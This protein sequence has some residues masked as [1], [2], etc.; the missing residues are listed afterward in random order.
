MLPAARHRVLAAH[1]CVVR[2]FHQIIRVSG[3]DQG[4]WQV[5]DSGP[6]FFVD[7]MDPFL[8]PVPR[9][10]HRQPDFCQELGVAPLVGEDSGCSSLPWKAIW[11]GVSGRC[12]QAVPKSERVAAPMPL[13]DLG[14]IWHDL[15]PEKVDALQ[16]FFRVH[17]QEV[18]SK[19]HVV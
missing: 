14:E 12:R 13:D 7:E 2:N 17:A 1:R 3:V 16:A 19:K 11:I 6:P 15:F 5:Q 8:G 10:T 18:N 9:E 4:L